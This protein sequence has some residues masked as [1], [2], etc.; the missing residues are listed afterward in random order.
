MTGNQEKK[1]GFF[2]FFPFCFRKLVLKS[3]WKDG[4]T[5]NRR[6]T[7]SAGEE[8]VASSGRNP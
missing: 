1:R 8:R 5:D 3:A 4:G 2:N 7:D 6:L